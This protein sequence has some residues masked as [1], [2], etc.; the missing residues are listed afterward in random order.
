MFLAVHFSSKFKVLYLVFANFFDKIH[1]EFE[2][3]ARSPF[4]APRALRPYIPKVKP[5]SE[6]SSRYKMP[7]LDFIGMKIIFA[8]ITLRY[9]RGYLIFAFDIAPNFSI[10]LSDEL[11]II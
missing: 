5:G 7:S 1:A 4:V 10:E 3:F 11:I 8:S 2:R 6:I 9:S